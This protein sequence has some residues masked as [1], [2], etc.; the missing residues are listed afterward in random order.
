MSKVLEG[1]SIYNGVT[2]GKIY[3]HGKRDGMVKCIP[4]EDVDRELA[5][6]EEAKQLASA[7]LEA[8]HRKLSDDHGVENAGIFEGQKMI[9]ADEV[10]NKSIRE[11]IQAQPVNAEY[12]VSMV[13]KQYMDAFQS[14]EDEY[15][16]ARSVDVKDVMLR[17]ISVLESCKDQEILQEPCIIMA[18]E[19]TPSE[20]VQMD[21]KKM[22]GLATRVGSANS[23]TSILART[24]G[25]PAVAG[26]EIS[27]EMD[28]LLGILDGFTGHLILEPDEEILA[29]YKKKMG[30]EG[31]KKDFLQQYKGRETV[32]RFGKRIGVY[33]NIGEL[34]DLDVVFENDA[35]GIGLFRSEFSYL[36]EDHFPTEEELFE[37]YKLLAVKMA[38]KRVVIRTLDIGTDKMVRYLELP[39]EENPA[40]GYR[41]IRICLTREEIFRTQL[42]A[43]L[44][45]SVYG[46]VEVMYPMITSLWEIRR[47]KEILKE[48]VLELEQEGILCGNIRQGIVIETPAAALISD[49]L[50]QEVD[51]FSIGTNDLAQYTLAADRQNP[52]LELFYDAK[53][54]AIMQLIKL[55]VDNAH[56]AGI[57]VGICGELGADESMTD[58]FMEMGI[59]ELS[60]APDRLLALKKAILG[61]N[62]LN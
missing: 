34:S 40:L 20:T 48:L 44:R 60:V 10:F 61:E 36:K 15:F 11:M 17:L 21:R 35:E 12:A 50:A 22:L 29:Y 62:S 3:Y 42:R 30:E 19:L 8:L 4:V 47:I 31:K 51:F 1:K 57:T 16:K 55:T 32:N 28:G 37:T 2:I 56:K 54:P 38:G 6:L 14:L 27:P 53:H 24:F 52:E 59:D 23:H 39:R 49:Q 7:Q 5:R 33:A 26:L 13:G 18:Q 46:R 41:A 43:I 58:T 45:A 9:L 25:I